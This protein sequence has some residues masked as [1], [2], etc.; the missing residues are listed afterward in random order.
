MWRNLRIY[1]N[2]RWWHRNIVLIGDALH[3]AHPSIGS[4]T[5]LAMEDAQALVD[6]LDAHRNDF[7]KAFEHFVHDRKPRRDAFGLAAERSF[8][9]YETIAM[10]IEQPILDFTYDF[11]T[12]T[13][14][15]DDVR[16]RSYAPEFY[17][18]YQRYSLSRTA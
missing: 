7:S 4:G 6:A 10:Q 18:D 2:E 1:A 11:L 16:L 15:I 5:R 17:E 8:E 9:W 12:R 13:G 3:T 14:R